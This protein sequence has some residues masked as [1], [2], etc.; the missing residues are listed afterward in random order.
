LPR[1][2]LSHYWQIPVIVAFVVI[3]Y[4]VFVNLLPRAIANVLRAIKATWNVFADRA[5]R[6]GR[7]PIGV[8]SRP[9]IRSKC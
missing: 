7:D 2:S 4:L 3:L 8:R 6:K 9:G 5:R 1:L